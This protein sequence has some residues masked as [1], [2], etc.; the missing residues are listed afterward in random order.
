MNKRY[1][2]SSLHQATIS[3]LAPGGKSWKSVV[4]QRGGIPKVYVSSSDQN[5]LLEMG[6]KERDPGDCRFEVAFAPSKDNL[7]DGILFSIR[8]RIHND[9][10]AANGLIEK[11]AE[12]S[13]GDG[14]PI[15]E[16]EL[17]ELLISDRGSIFKQLEKRA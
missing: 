2:V 6:S 7:R 8:E 14:K 10:N 12:D 15:T 1:I 9:I 4:D 17:A 16:Q 5:C 11:L 13:L 3:C